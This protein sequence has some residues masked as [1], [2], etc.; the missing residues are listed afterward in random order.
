M[1]AAGE[2]KRRGREKGSRRESERE[3]K[4]ERTQREKEA[5]GRTEG[6]Q[7]HIDARGVEGTVISCNG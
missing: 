1:W 5:D 3:K 4:D 6:V 7:T 2:R